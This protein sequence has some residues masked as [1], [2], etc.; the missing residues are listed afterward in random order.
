MKI[1]TKWKYKMPIRLDKHDK[2]TFGLKTYSQRK[3]KGDQ[4]RSHTHTC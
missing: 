3:D 2:P 4:V 1:L